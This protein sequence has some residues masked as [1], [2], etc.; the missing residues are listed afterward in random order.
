MPC[1]AH[2]CVHAHAPSANWFPGWRAKLLKMHGRGCHGMQAA[3]CRMPL[4]AAACPAACRAGVPAAAVQQ[5]QQGLQALVATY[6]ARLQPGT[7]ECYRSAFN[8]VIVRG[9]TVGDAAVGGIQQLHARRLRGFCA[10]RLSC[11]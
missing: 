5:D 7:Q 2:A 10:T 4:Q 6:D 8:Q 11:L 1:H 9:G 3:T